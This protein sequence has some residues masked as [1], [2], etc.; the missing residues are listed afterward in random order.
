MIFRVLVLINAH[1]LHLFV[2]TISINMSTVEGRQL[3]RNCPLDIKKRGEFVNE[4]Q[5]RNEEIDV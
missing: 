1:E 5:L 4:S 2:Y 3:I